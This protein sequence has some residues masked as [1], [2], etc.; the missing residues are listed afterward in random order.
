MS[1]ETLVSA[2]AAITA[3][4]GYKAPA[5]WGLGLA[6]YHSGRI[7]APAADD[8]QILDTWFPQVSLGEDLEAAAIVADAVGNMTG[9][10]APRLMPPHSQRLPS[11]LLLWPKMVTA[12]PQSC[13]RSCWRDRKTSNHQSPLGVVATFIGDLDDEAADAHDVYLR[14]HL[15]S[16]RKI[17]PMAVISMEFLVN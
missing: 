5:A 10:G 12:C 1:Q 9:T 17:K 16:H 6:H 11:G 7:G 4:E 8:A 3:K 13:V 2:A 15:L 14:L